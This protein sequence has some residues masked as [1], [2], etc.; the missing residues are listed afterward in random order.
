MDGSCLL[1]AGLWGS[2]IAGGDT[3]DDAIFKGVGGAYGYMEGV[4]H[5]G[6]SHTVF[7]PTTCAASKLSM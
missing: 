7:L 3:L 5:G 1:A 4:Q 2:R 6:A